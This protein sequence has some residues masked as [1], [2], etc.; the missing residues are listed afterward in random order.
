MDTEWRFYPTG[1]WIVRSEFNQACIP[2]ED[3]GPNKVGFSSGLIDVATTSNNGPTFQV[4]VNDTNPIFFYCAAPDSCTRYHMV[5][6]INP[7][8]T[9][10]YAEQLESAETAAYQMT[11][12]EAFPSETASSPTSSSSSTP[13]GAS[14]SSSDSHHSLSTGAIAGIAIGGAAVVVLAAAL[15]YLCGRRGGKDSAFAR[16][17]SQATTLNGPLQDVRYEGGPVGAKSPGQ[18]TFHTTTYSAHPSN[19]P[20]QTP[21]HAG[22]YGGHP[23]GL[24]P[25]NYSVSSA[26]PPPMS[27]YSVQTGFL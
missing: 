5:G 20:Y 19:D 13:G 6:V 24:M 1:H 27:E 18:E 22:Q 9:Q 14:S 11:P 17:Q 4:R 3:T 21:M 2:Y 7:N 15:L 8:S 23:H 16:R 26:S 10:T 12:G 25:T